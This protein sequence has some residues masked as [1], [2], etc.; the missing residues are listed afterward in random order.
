MTEP[1]AKEALLVRFGSLVYCDPDFYPVAR[2]DEASAAAEHLAAMRADAA[3]WAAIAAR[4]GFDPTSDPSGDALLAT[5]RDWK[6]L[7]ALALTASGDGWA[8]DASFG[9]TGPGASTSQNI[10][11][12]AGTI[13]TDGTIQVDRQEPS[14]PPPCPICLARGTAIA[15]PAG[16]VA[17]E[18]LQ[19]GDPVW[20]RDRL[21][22]RV[23]AVIVEV[24]STA[25]P[26]T[27]E[28]VRLILADGRTV[29]VSPG[30]P[31]PDG[32]PVA[33][34]QADD[35]YDGS[36]VRS[37]DRLPYTGGRTFDLLPSGGTG[38]Y[39]ANG[40]ALGSTLFR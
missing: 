18:A 30:H 28:V 14:G 4:H 32:R 34:L 13:A 16:D 38:I 5:Y 37:V 19:L 22:R 6:M 2:A 33:A 29:L 31:L 27:H 9:G 23:H 40:I 15:T 35:A 25:V 7:R 1:A 24:G 20:T 3:A 11:H 26:P 8:F 10:T 17:V 36:V 21:G 12:V 39:W